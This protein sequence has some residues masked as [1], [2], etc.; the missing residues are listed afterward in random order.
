MLSRILWEAVD[1]RTP[2]Y[3]PNGLV[4]HRAAYGG[5]DVTAG[6]VG[7][8]GRGRCG[9]GRHDRLGRLRLIKLGDGF[10]HEFGVG[11]DANLQPHVILLHLL[12]QH[13][14]DELHLLRLVGAG[15]AAGGLGHEHR[16]AGIAGGSIGEAMRPD[17]R[18]GKPA[19]SADSPCG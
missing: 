5:D 11:D 2:P 1:Q 14:G 7:G 18:I 13:A 10:A 12:G 17:R 9:F 6:D 19:E 15:A 4:R 3:T 8:V 16:T